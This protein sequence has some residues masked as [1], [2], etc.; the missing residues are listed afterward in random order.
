MLLDI[1]HDL[2]L[3]V[4]DVQCPGGSV[5]GGGTGA[6]ALFVGGVNIADSLVEYYST[7][8]T[9]ELQHQY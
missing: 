3:F 9:H 1:V 6:A 8:A 7:F 4:A 2:S 5:A